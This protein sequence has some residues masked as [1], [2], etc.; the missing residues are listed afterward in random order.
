MEDNGMVTVSGWLAG[1]IDKV[2]IED[3]RMI[4]VAERGRGLWTIT[5][6]C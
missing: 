1:L 5:Q 4:T 3:N 6:L 2:S